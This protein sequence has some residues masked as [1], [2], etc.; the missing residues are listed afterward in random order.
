MNEVERTAEGAGDREARPRYCVV[1]LDETR[2]W[3]P[4]IVRRAKRVLCVYLFNATRRVHCCEFMPSYECL[5]VESQ[6]D[7]PELPDCESDRL[8]VDI[9]QGDNASEPVRYF[10]CHQI[11][12]LPRID[13]GDVSVGLIDLGIEDKEEAFEY[14]RLR[15]I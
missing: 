11:D 9:L 5:F 15:A 8:S 3:S 13:E 6:W 14:L 10:H 2:C 12:D 7:N 1:K 4:D